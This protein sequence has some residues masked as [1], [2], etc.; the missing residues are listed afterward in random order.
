M[1]LTEHVEGDECKFAAWTG[2]TAMGENR[3]I[4]KVSNQSLVHKIDS[5]SSS[6][7]VELSNHVMIESILISF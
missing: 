6:F 4:L 7:V 3:L 1:G 2:R 5:A